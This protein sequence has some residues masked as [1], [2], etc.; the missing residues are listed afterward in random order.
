MRQKSDEVVLFEK[1]LA[2]ERVTGTLSAVE[3]VRLDEGAEFKGDAKLFR[4]HTIC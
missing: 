4:R 3:V 1:F 2:D